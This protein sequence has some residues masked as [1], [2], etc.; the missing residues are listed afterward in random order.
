MADDE[1]ELQTLSKVLF[2]LVE[3]F[4]EAQNSVKS[5]ALTAP[6]PTPADGDRYIVANPGTAA[7]LNHS[8]QLARFDGTSWGFYVPSEGMSVWVDDEDK[9]V[10][11]NGTSWRT[12]SAAGRL[13]P[14]N[15]RL[16]ARTTV[17]DGDLACNTALLAQPI[18]AGY[19]AVRVNG[20]AVP[21]VGDGVAT[22]VSCYFTAPA[23]PD[24]RALA[25]LTQGDVLR[26][27]GSVAGYQLA[28]SDVLDIDYEVEG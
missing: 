26:W 16:T 18:A 1:I 28:P 4:T 17:N 12:T 14:L 5:R 8:L 6:P 15:K 13:T 20:V 2:Q 21:D 27:N 7:W 19:V 11:F 9:H 3:P 24:P 22:G 25:Q 10:T 23:S